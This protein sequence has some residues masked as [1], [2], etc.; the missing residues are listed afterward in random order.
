MICHKHKCIFIHIPRTGGTSIEQSIRPDWKLHKFCNEK[1]IIASTAKRIYS[2][3]W[4]EYFKFAFVRNP[5]DRMV[6]MAK[7]P[8]FYGCKIISSKI[9]VSG[10]IEKY[11]GTEIDSRT[12]SV[13]DEVQPIQNA[14]YKNILNEELDFIGKFENIEQD[15]NKVCAIINCSNKLIHFEKYKERERDYTE[16]YTDETQ[17][18]V[19]KKY[20]NDIIQHGYTFK[21]K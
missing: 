13:H 2:E 16:Y 5:W 3:Y 15:Y 4:D 18:L 17:A 19:A 6:S 12:E 11:P 8:R 14:V 20:E 7:Y 10:Y 1:H 21:N 9:D